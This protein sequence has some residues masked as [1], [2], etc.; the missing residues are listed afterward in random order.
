MEIHKTAYF[1]G[2]NILE[3]ALMS[4]PTSKS[5]QEKQAKTYK[6]RGKRV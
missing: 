3:T 6:I 4:I 5:L 2:Q 1:A